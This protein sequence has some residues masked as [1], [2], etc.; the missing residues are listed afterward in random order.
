MALPFRQFVQ[1]QDA[2]M[3]QRDLAGPGQWASVIYQENRDLLFT[4][5]QS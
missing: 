5:L 3:G 4:G 1:E 2:V